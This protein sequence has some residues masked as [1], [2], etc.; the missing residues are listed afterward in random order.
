M[1]MDFGACLHYLG[2]GQVSFFEAT[3]GDE[4]PRLLE[5][6]GHNAILLFTDV[7]CP[8]H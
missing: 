4:A 3:S 8:A 7:E 5:R 1:W 6:Q 2:G